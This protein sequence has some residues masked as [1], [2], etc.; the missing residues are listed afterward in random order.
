MH[1]NERPSLSTEQLAQ[2]TNT[3]ARWLPSSE[4]AAAVSGW[5]LAEWEAA[6]W[7]VYWQ[8]ALPWLVQRIRKSGAVV[9]EPVRERLFELD[10]ESR[11]RTKR[12]MAGCVAL[13][14]ALD[15]AGIEAIPF[16]GAALA[17]LYYPDPLL[18][19]LADL[20]ILIHKKRLPQSL[21]IL[22]QLG[23]RYYS[24][25]AE[26]VVYLRGER[27]ANIWAADNV[28]PVELHY[29][30]REEYAGI[31]YNL[32]EE[33]WRSSWKR[34]FW[35]GFNARIPNTPTLLHHVCAH[36]TSD[37][38]IQRGRLMHIDDIRKLCARMT[39]M[40]WGLFTTA[41][42]PYGARFVYPALAFAA[43]YSGR[44]IPDSVETYL[45]QNCPEALLAW[46]ETTKLAD[47][48]ESNPTVRSGI[49][50]D[51]ARL[52]ARSRPDMARFWLRSFFPRR[53]NLSKRYPR[54]VK[55]P[56]WPLAYVLINVDRMYHLARKRVS[57]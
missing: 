35:D 26:D 33:L 52:L 1:L 25:S 57:I 27:K 50:F 14:K 21:D 42:P 30:L 23:Y 51:I 32:A 48:S 34:P 17:P 49:G 37:W 54:L 9:P 10:R 45:R 16:K 7:V 53:W 13:L 40:D 56:F 22:R 46:I 19:P 38:L 29:T 39:D 3:L 31:G 20:D 28:H 15:G 11:E 44:F 36:A 2:V 43:R 8:N 18:R 12:M 41:V 6:E 4:G 47:V 5:G 55:T 24:R